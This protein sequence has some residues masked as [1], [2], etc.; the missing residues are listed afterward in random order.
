M[1]DYEIK[2]TNTNTL[3]YNNNNTT[4]INWVDKLKPS[5]KNKTIQKRYSNILIK[6]DDEL[7]KYGILNVYEKSDKGSSSNKR[8]DEGSG[9]STANDPYQQQWNKY[10]I[11]SK[12]QSLKIETS[13][14]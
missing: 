2:T 13:N 6:E 10:V 9:S 1:Y 11:Q 8:S 12:Y 7:T 3:T 14:I 4:M 5:Q